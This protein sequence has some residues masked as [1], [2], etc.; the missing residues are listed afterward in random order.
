[1]FYIICNPRS[2]A[3]RL[4]ISFT[5]KILRAFP[6]GP[7]VLSVIINVIPSASISTSVNIEPSISIQFADPPIF[8]GQ[9]AT[10]NVAASGCDMIY[11]W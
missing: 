3:T 11:Q 10:L 4:S 7:A 8:S 9:S 5:S 6:G 1:M 2:G